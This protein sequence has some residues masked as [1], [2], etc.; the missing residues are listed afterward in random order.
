V[1]VRR[2]EIRHWDLGSSI[3][4]ER[5][6]AFT[7]GETTKY[8]FHFL[9]C[10]ELSLSKETGGRSLTKINR[11]VKIIPRKCF[12]EEGLY[13]IRKRRKTENEKY[14]QFTIEKQKS[15]LVMIYVEQ[16]RG[17]KVYYSKKYSRE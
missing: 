9:N 5:T 7:Q 8:C 14:E 16:E 17:E 13:S 15:K 4:I 11:R 3:E 2:G 12:L 6:H 1:C 10:I